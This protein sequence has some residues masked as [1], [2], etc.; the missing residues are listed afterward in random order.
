LGDDEF[1][2]DFT[3]LKL[4]TKSSHPVVQYNRDPSIPAPGTMVTVM[5]TGDT[6]PDKPSRSDVL[7]EASLTVIGNEQC[8]ESADPDDID[9]SY[10]GRIHPSM[11]CTTGGPHNEKDSW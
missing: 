3:I 10:Q 8:E 6:N 2:H 1:R 4:A 5:G 11:M 9:F 7:R